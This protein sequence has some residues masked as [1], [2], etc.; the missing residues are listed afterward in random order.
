MPLAHLRKALP[1]FPPKMAPSSTDLLSPI[2]FSPNPKAYTNPQRRYRHPY[3]IEISNAQYPAFARVI[4]DPISYQPYNNT[5]ATW[6]DTPEAVIDM[7]NELKQAKEIAVDV[8]HHDE[9]SYIGL[10]SLMQISTR[11]QDWVIDTLN[12]WREDLQ[13]LNEVFTNPEIIKVSP[14]I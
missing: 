2:G 4:S 8:E 9:H 10:V 3:E 1:S 6:V 12:P 11:N 5:K 7:L 14:R 13:V